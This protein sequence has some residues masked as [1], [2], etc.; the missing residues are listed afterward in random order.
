MQELDDILGKIENLQIQQLIAQGNPR[1]IDAL[2]SD[3]ANLQYWHPIRTVISRKKI[4]KKRIELLDAAKEAGANYIDR[5]IDDIDPALRGIVKRLNYLPFIS[6]VSNNCSGHKADF[7]S[8]AYLHVGFRLDSKK[9]K[10]DIVNFV[11]GIQNIQIDNT[12]KLNMFNQPQPD[13]YQFST[14]QDV[15]KLIEP[16][17]ILYSN[18]SLTIQIQEGNPSVDHL[19]KLWSAFSDVIAKFEPNAKEELFYK[20]MFVRDVLGGLGYSGG[21]VM[22]TVEDTLII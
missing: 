18:T 6:Y 13:A 20:E 21:K 5:I 16:N 17:N 12:E 22:A 7:D 14:V 19:I 15:Q 2:E 11:E 4:I 10:K 1:P 3:L 9:N 8:H